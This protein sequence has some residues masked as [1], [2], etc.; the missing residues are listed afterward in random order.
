VIEVEHLTKFFGE[1]AAIRDLTFQV[2]R[3]EIVGLLGPNGA[4]KT[5]TMRILTTFLSPTSGRA[6]VHGHDCQAE[7]MEVRRAVGYL[8]E[9]PP[10]YQEMTVLDYLEFVA[11]L[12]E[13]PSWRRAPAVDRAVE[14]SGLGD[15]R[16]RL[17]GNL[18]KGYRQRTG[19]AQALVA[20]PPVLV[21]DEP[22]I[23]LDPNQIQEVR[24]LIGTLAGDHTILLSTHIL[25]E[26]EGTCSRV[27]IIDA[28]EI[29][30]VDTIERLRALH[31]H[32]ERICLQVARDEPRVG[33]TLARL[34]G[35]QTV[36]PDESA[37]GRYLVEGDSDRELCESLAERIV[38]EGWGLLELTRLD[39]S[40]EEVFS[41]LT[42]ERSATD[43][44]GAPQ[45]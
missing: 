8:P 4:G 10:L 36:I 43:V 19:L 31:R 13:I 34:P 23:G 33:T 20:E 32:G 28:G 14:R 9:S 25:S 6:L 40:L 37:P 29:A 3:G 11:A 18:S 22:T 27:A 7:P 12:K 45:A 44:D 2:G 38:E 41:R 42:V 30:A 35:V 26:V 16:E 15:V 21:L 17:I 39:L 24:R 1:R 5:T